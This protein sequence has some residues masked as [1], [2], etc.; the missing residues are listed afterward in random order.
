[1]QY[2]TEFTSVTSPDLVGT[3]NGNTICIDL[4]LS[5]FGANRPIGPTLYNV[6][7]FSGGRNDAVTDVYTE[8]DSTRSF[9]FALG[10]I[11]ATPLVSVVSRKVHG[12]AG[13]FD[14]NLPLTGP[15]GVEC[16]SGGANSDYTMVFSFSGLVAN[17]GTASSGTVSN[18]PSPNQCTVNLTGVPNAQYLT[19]TLTGVNVPTAC[20][21][22]F[23][24]NASGTMGVL[25]GDTTATGTVNASDVGQTKAR[26][27]QITASTNF[28]S[29]VNVNGV[30]NAA[31]VALVKSKSG[32]S[33]PTPP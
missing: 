20:P 30:I 25:V 14:I 27:G 2:P 32:S 28:R 8:G 1:V 19:V 31:D 24:G 7:A 26:S 29:D 33:L 13:T 9:D 5:L 22:S 12:S 15:R 6:S 10:N 3:I 16:R 4:P 17:C 18:G 21:S 23:T 11:T